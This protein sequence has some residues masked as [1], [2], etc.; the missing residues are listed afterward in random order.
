MAVGLQFPAGM[1]RKRSR[2]KADDSP[3]A[4]MDRPPLGGDGE[5]AEPMRDGKPA[6]AR[7][8]DPGFTPPEDDADPWQDEG[9]PEASG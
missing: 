9:H 3:K 1:A 8:Y 6:M 2:P 7:K 5:R 4:D